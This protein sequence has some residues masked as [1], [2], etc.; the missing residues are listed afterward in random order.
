MDH[1]AVSD[2]AAL[3]F[4]VGGSLTV[5]AAASFAVRRLARRPLWLVAAAVTPSLALV[6]VVPGFLV[7]AGPSPVLSQVF[8]L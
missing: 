4:A 6:R 2:V 5:V 1:H 3:C 7:R 8:R